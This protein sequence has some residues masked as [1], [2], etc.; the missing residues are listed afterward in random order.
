VRVADAN[1]QGKGFKRMAILRYSR[2]LVVVLSLLAICG[3]AR[4]ADETKKHHTP[5]SY[6]FNIGGATP[7]GASANSYSSSFMIGGGASLPIG[8]WVSVDW[9]S[10]D[11]GF[12][13]TG[14][15][16]TISVTDGSSRKTKNYQMMFGSGGR[17]NLPLGRSAALG[18]GGGIGV[19][20]Q[21]EYVP[22]RVYYSGGVRVIESVD[23]TNARG[24]PSMDRFSRSVCMAGR[25]STRA[26]G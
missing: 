17:V 1:Q 4:A 20:E 10:M 8:R 22:D 23:C 24:G 2:L 5:F 12:G 14:V 26:L 11:F 19:V 9:A 7:A 25:T 15:S 6:E 13:T 18:L 21:N 16:R 3:R